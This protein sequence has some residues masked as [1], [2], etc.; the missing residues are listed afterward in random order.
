MD[1][2]VW[3]T[4]Y[5]IYEKAVIPREYWDFYPKEN[6]CLVKSRL[7]KVAFAKNQLENN[8]ETLFKLFKPFSNL[9]KE[10]NY[11]EL[12]TCL[13][14]KKRVVDDFVSI[15]LALDFIR[16]EKDRANW[17]I[18]N[19]IAPN[20]V[21]EDAF[22]EN[23]TLRIVKSKMSETS[24]VIVQILSMY[25]NCLALSNENEEICIGK[26]RIQE[27]SF[28]KKRL[29]QAYKTI[30]YLLKQFNLP[31]PKF[32][33][34]DLK[35]LKKDFKMSLDVVEFLLAMAHASGFVRYEDSDKKN[36]SLL[37]TD[38]YILYETLQSH[39]VEEYLQVKKVEKNTNLGDKLAFQIMD[40]YK[41]SLAQPYDKDI[42]IGSNRFITVIF[43]KKT[44]S[45]FSDAISKII[46]SV[47][48]DKNDFSFNDLKIIENRFV[49][50]KNDF[51]FDYLLAMATAL[52][53][54]DFAPLKEGKLSD[55]KNP[56]LS[57]SSRSTNVQ[58]HIKEKTKKKTFM[59]D[60]FLALMTTFRFPVSK[61]KKVH[62]LK[63]GENLA[64]R[65]NLMYEK[66]LAQP[67]DKNI[68]YGCNRNEVIAFNKNKLEFVLPEIQK[69]I[70]QLAIHTQFFTYE[71]LK[72][73]EK[74]FNWIQDET[75]KDHLL[76]MANGLG[77]IQFS[78]QTS[79]CEEDEVNPELFISDVYFREKTRQRR[80]KI[81]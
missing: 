66:C 39:Y 68:W 33:F 19:Y 65:I 52:R 62:S 53:I 3:E 55:V 15:G 59:S 67:N 25:R 30:Y 73:R 78:K 72:I 45:Q 31:I 61:Q 5:Q 75:V 47:L 36:P 63:N 40:I 28:N 27:V 10:F 20:F 4:F 57:Y 26:N 34:N 64:H 79:E 74:D 49:W 14:S 48:G 6:F 54:L 42:C 32:C 50:D 56:R 38:D 37:L 70:E 2:K 16:Y 76:A 21:F 44:L 24:S 13:N 22:F 77:I 46:S 41:K 51:V 81:S 1:S 7:E 69:I 71:D 35:V 58:I 9:G 17:T 11:K 43:N 29:N 8:Y 12:A 18:D 80:L 60:K 23:Q